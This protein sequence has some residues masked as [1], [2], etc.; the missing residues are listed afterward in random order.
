M[1]AATMAEAPAGALRAWFTRG[2]FQRS[3]VWVAF[4]LL[5]LFNVVATSRFLTVQT[6]QTNLT[7][8]SAVGIAAVGMTLIIATGG[9]DLSVGSLMALAGAASGLIMLSGASWVNTAIGSA[10]VIVTGVAV[11]VAFG[12]VNG[13]LVARL[14]V[15]PIVATLVVLIA[16]RGIAQLA[17]SGRLFTVDNATII[18][19]GRGDLLGISVQAWLL[20][21]VMAVGLWVVRA[22]VFGRQVFAVGG[23][24]RAAELAGVRTARVKYAVY[25]IGGLLA[26]IAGILS[27][28]INGTVDAANLGLG[29]EFLAISAVVVGGTPL[30]GGRPRLWGTLG[31]VALLQL[32]TFTLTSHNIPKETANLVQAAVIVAAVALQLRGRRN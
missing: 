7:Q 13:F 2:G 23:N 26:G 16:G 20:A 1:T 18:W 22:T 11:A 21:A 31:G 29:W 6:L 14:R 3:G 9:I 25:A 4:A 28:G 5:V 27:I 17:S 15:Q 30:T 19:L 8:L 24:E 32:L 10:V 12:F